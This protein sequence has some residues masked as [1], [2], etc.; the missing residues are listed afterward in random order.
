MTSRFSKTYTRKGGEASSKFDE[1]FSNRKATLST[2][3]GETTYK[4]QL[5]VKRPSFKP[6]VPELTKRPRF[7]DDDSSEDP[8]GFDSDDESKTVTSRGTPQSEIGSDAAES[9]NELLK[10]QTENPSGGTVVTGMGT[11]SLGSSSNISSAVVGM[12]SPGKK[13]TLKVCVCNSCR[14]TYECITGDGS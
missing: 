4:A 8:F 10:T 14:N 3:W 1:V 6:E 12:N 13:L 9:G 5:G 2:K 7:D 11:S